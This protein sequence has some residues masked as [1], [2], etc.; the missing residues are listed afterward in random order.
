MKKLLLIS[1]FV[2]QLEATIFVQ[3]HTKLSYWI[4]VRSAHS[5]Q[6][7]FIPG[8]GNKIMSYLALQQPSDVIDIEVRGRFF[9]LLKRMQT[10]QLDEQKGTVIIAGDPQRHG[11]F[12]RALVY[13]FTNPDHRQPS[14]DSPRDT[15]PFRRRGD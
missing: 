10:I 11:L 1:L 6:T 15:N 3:N 8:R 14:P 13:L 9:S 2:G 7:I 5:A 4:M 12:P